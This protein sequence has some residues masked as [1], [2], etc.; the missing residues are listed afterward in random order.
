MPSGLP[1][2]EALTTR[3]VGAF[4]LDTDVIQAA[5]FRF[6]DGQLRRLSS[7]LPPWMQLWLSD[8]VVREIKAHRMD[9]IRRAVLQVKGAHSDLRRLIAGHSLGP[10]VDPTYHLQT[11]FHLFDD[12][13]RKFVSHH[14]GLVIEAGALAISSRM[15]ARYFEGS[16]PFGGGRDKKHEFPDAAT[17]LLLE[18]QAVERGIKLIAVSNDEGWMKFSEGSSHL[19]CVK[20]LSDLTNLFVAQSPEIKQFAVRVRHHLAAKDVQQEVRTLLHKG[21]VAGPWHVQTQSGGW[22]DVDAAVSSV[23]L[24]TF[25]LLPDSLRIWTTSPD[26][27]A[28]V[29]EVAVEADLRVEIEAIAYR[30]K[31]SSTTEEDLARTR[32]AVDHRFEGTVVME[33]QGALR[34][35][36]PGMVLTRMALLEQTLWVKLGRVKFASLSD[37][38]SDDLE[39]DIPF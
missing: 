1:S 36:E 4:S 24:S 21:P 33:F 3:E 30:H 27:T 28:C 26:E 2:S 31:H 39:D 22:Y 20:A 23:K 7:Q 5:G 11:A 37:P 12:Q 10:L 9:G 35:A 17:L 34:N 13:L 15:F 25:Q 16:P 19:Y 8:I 18:S 14:N 32:Q 38:F 29:A 6:D